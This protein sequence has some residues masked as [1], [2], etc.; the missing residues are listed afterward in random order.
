MKLN[1]NFLN[2]LPYWSEALNTIAFQ[3]PDMESHFRDSLTKNNMD[4]CVW[5]VETVKPIV[6]EESLRQEGLRV[7][8]LNGWLGIPLIPLL[9]ENLSIAVFD[10][11]EMDARANNLSRIFNKHYI[12]NEH[13]QFRYHTLDAPFAIPQLNAMTPDI[14][15]NLQCEQMFPLTDLRVSN[16]FAIYAMQSSD[17]P[18]EMMGI[19]CVKGEAEFTS[20][21]GLT[22]IYSASK[23]IQE[24]YTWEGRKFYDRYQAIGTKHPESTASNTQTLQ[25]VTLPSADA[26]LSPGSLTP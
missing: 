21:L 12:Q 4:A 16:P 10:I 15:I 25:S 2:N 8:V 22:T 23:R 3:Q 6:E 13:I 14:V 5:L 17:I 9:C 18:E 26:S 20:Q 19:N 7:L 1:F 24:M 11:V